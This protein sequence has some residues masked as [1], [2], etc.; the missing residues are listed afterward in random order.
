MVT[1][2]HLVL[3]TMRLQEQLAGIGN[4]V[5]RFEKQMEEL[6]NKEIEVFKAMYLKKRELRYL[7]FL[8][9]YSLELME[10][11]QENGKIKT[12]KTEVFAEH[13][14]ELGRQNPEDVA[15]QLKLSTVDPLLVPSIVMYRCIAQE[16]GTGEVW[17]PGNN[18]SDGIAYQ[19]ASENKLLKSVH[20]FDNDVLSAATNLSKRYH[21]YSPHI[22]AL[23]KMSTMIFHAIQKVHGMGSRELLLLQVAAIL[24]DCGK[25][26]SLANGP[27]CAYDIIMA[28]E[29]IG[30]SHLEREIVA[31]TVRYN[32]RPLDPYERVA[33]KM[34]VQSYMTAA[35]LAAILR[36][37]NALD[38]SHKQKFSTI[39]VVLKNKE[40]LI[41]VETKDDI[42]L[43]KG[44]LANKS[45][46]FEAIFGIKPVLREKR[47][48]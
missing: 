23:T 15:E 48:L 47:K 40:L 7:I 43:E 10:S 42:I 8:G 38:R 9:D 5:A 37:S 30:L 21:S 28:S 16:L 13:L 36:V 20:D 27:D 46:S 24:H 18:I 33:D 11:I 2:Q 44:L 31:S 25:F 26:V 12:A 35:K 32:T 17:V 41:T 39:K 3:G 34:D 4:T 14:K 6:I 1:T 29:I 22:D 19:Y 45:D